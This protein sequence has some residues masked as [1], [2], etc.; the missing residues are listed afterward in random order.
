MDSLPPNETREIHPMTARKAFATLALCV[1]VGLL[2]T[3]LTGCG[4]FEKL[5]VET[6][7]REE[8]LPKVT[9]TQ[10]GVALGSFVVMIIVLKYL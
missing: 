2:L 7:E 6:P 5:G 10:M 4:I 8:E 9:K 3:P 1:L